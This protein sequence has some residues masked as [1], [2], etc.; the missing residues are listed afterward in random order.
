MTGYAIPKLFENEVTA[1]ETSLMPGDI[2]LFSKDPTGF[3]V[4]RN[5][6]LLWWELETGERVSVWNPGQF[7]DWQSSAA[8][9]VDY[10][11]LSIVPSNSSKQPPIQVRPSAWLVV[12]IS[13]PA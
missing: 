10:F 4:E 1:I 3:K 13:E 12:R 2:I 9:I 8:W 11:R 6:V 5:E 7:G